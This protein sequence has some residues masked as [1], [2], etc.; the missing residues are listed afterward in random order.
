V[1]GE[2]EVQV[3]EV[4]PDGRRIRLSRNAVLEAAQRDDLRE[5]TER[6][7]PSKSEGFGSLADKLRSALKK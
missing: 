3:L 6:S 1:G 7:E 2:V 4:A 5:Y